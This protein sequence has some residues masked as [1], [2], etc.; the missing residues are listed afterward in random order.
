MKFHE[1]SFDDYIDEMKKKDFH[2]E[3]DEFYKRLPQNKT[4][5]GNLLLYG[6][7]GTGKY[8]QSL[9]IIKQYSPSCLKYEKKMCLNSD[10]YNYVYKISDIH[11][12]IDF[13]LLGC[14]AKLVWHEIFLQIVDIISMSTIKTGIILCKNF[15]TIHPEL[16]PIFYSYMH[17]YNNITL[18]F[19]IKYIIITEQISFITNNIL[20][21][22]KT[23]NV[24]QMSKEIYYDY[25]KLPNH[26]DNKCLMNLK[27]INML[28]MIEDDE[29]LPSESFDVI[30]ESIK[31]KMNNHKRL[32]LLEFRELIYDVLVY[33]LDFIEVVW[34]IISYYVQEG[35]LGTENLKKILKNTY[36]Q[37]KQYNNN[38][39]PIYHLE[40]IL[41]NI[42][43]CIK[44]ESR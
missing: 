35:K 14:N 28:K 12:E 6:P 3:L 27:E 40:N 10:K 38:Y 11:Y 34:D 15:H 8:S 33:N 41:L 43:N 29:N 23:I 7:P 1:T 25:L 18:P 36:N 17:Q 22:V 2:P 44:N 24:K 26:I 5:M 30:C 20:N 42:I 39:R 37:F 13:A 16:L 4:N 31:Q 19:H 32:D 21:Y 9:K